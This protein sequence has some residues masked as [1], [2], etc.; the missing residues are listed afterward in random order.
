MARIV[1]WLKT[2][3]GLEE[4]EEPSWRSRTYARPRAR[5]TP[6]KPAA[7]AMAKLRAVDFAADVIGKIIDG[8][9]GKNVLIRNKYTL[10][11][12]ATHETVKIL[13]DSILESDEEIGAYPYNT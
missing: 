8:G 7:P 4:P 11:D 12:T 9:P 13:D 2:K 1:D 10:A 5:P 3:L 6:G